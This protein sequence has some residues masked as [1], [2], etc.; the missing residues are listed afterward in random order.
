MSLVSEKASNGMIFMLDWYGHVL[1]ARLKPD[2]YCHA[3]V[4]E[5]LESS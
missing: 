4:I 2:N 3:N 5:R 1:R